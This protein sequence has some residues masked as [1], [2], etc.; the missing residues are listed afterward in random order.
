MKNN[1]KIL[2][3]YRD[4]YKE[5]SADLNLWNLL[6]LN[7]QD[8]HILSG[9]DDLGT[10]FLPRLALPSEFAANMQ[11]RVAMYQR[12]KVLIYTSFFL[13]G[14]M[15]INGESKSIVAP[16]LYNEAIIEQ[17]EHSH[18]FS[19]NH[20]TPDVNG[21]L[22]QLLTPEDGAIPESDDVRH[23]Q[24]TDLWAE[25]AKA[26]NQNV[27]YLSLLSFPKLATKSDIELALKS[28][29]LHLMPVSMLALVDRSM[30]SRG[31]IHEL[32]KIIESEQLSPPLR[33]LFNAPKNRIQKN[34]VQYEYL[35]GLLSKAQ[36]KIVSIAANSDIG[37]VSGPPGTGKSYTIAAVAAEHLSRHQSVLIVAQTEAALEVIS[38]KL[39]QN[40]NLGDVSIRAGQ[41]VHLRKLKEY[42]DNL[43]S[44][45]HS[46]S[47]PESEKD[48]A[49][50][51]KKLNVHLS[52]IERQFVKD[53]QRAIRRGQRIKRLEKQQQDFWLNFY[54]IFARRNIRN[55]SGQ[56][57]KLSLMNQW[58]QEREDQAS[59]YL[60]K[61]KESN[62]KALINK[63]RKSLQAFN[64]AVR[65]RTSKRQSEYFDEI[66]FKALL[67]A[68]PVWLVSLNTLH[69]VLPLSRE[70]FE[71][72]IVDEATQCNISS[73]LPAFYR[74]KRALVVG[75]TKQLR[76][77]SF[78]ARERQQHILQAHQLTSAT[79]GICSYRDHSILDLALESLNSDKQVAFL[80]EH[81]RSKPE[82][83]D[84]SNRHFYQNKLKIMQHRPCTSSGFLHRVEVDGSRDKNGVNRQES[85]RIMKMVREYVEQQ[86]DI[87]IKTSIG[88]I[89]P[90]RNQ[91]EHIAKQV[92]KAFS[93]AEIE[94]HQ[95]RVS[96]PYGFQGEERDIMFLS[97]SLDNHSKRAVA[98]LNKTDVFNVAITRARQK[99]Y[100][101]LSISEDQL[102]QNNLLKKYLQSMTKFQI[103]HI[104]NHDID[105]FQDMVKSALEAQNI[106]C[107]TGY[108][109]AGHAI[110]LLCRLNGS[111]LAL[112]L[113]GYPGPWS[114]FFELNTYKIFK[115]AGIP[116]LPISYGIWQI[117]RQA[118]M[119]AILASLKNGHPSGEGSPG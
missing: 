110:D 86:S 95:I 33:G 63:H 103:E 83:I 4:C 64:K 73:C 38:N 91:A 11:K 27:D 8:L 80:D 99:Q 78:L 42:L 24:S 52:R 5:D 9:Q 29:K 113:I 70:M 57:K 92:E 69:K 115:R 71:L 35:P 114:A 85:D 2:S 43:L 97:F 66:E 55:F 68:F 94:S 77:Y 93:Q 37:C 14:K 20:E 18:Y 40:F 74:A 102:P 84:F 44:G 13:V 51:L 12:E 119:R 21:A 1:Q 6:K 60:T 31:I 47:S 90:Y 48:I 116:I 108:T 17:D 7:Q 49:K 62:L 22:V 26:A 88:I 82:L 96:T 36:Q 100:L 75:D 105:E 50:L 106:E 61:V 30:S 104:V 76:H 72:V 46:D 89:S 19:L 59:R 58:L 56:W 79:N 39:E 45:Y 109:I 10:R 98:Y 107:W 54:L 117:D 118:C 32:D 23:L 25:W 65:S 3:Y 87:A 101:L 112:D 15:N 16:I 67:S 41:K 53:C 28:D 111:Y 81:F 34:K